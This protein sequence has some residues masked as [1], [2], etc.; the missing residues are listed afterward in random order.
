MEIREGIKV[1]TI[2][3]LLYAI[4]HPGGRDHN[5]D[6]FLAMSL[7]DAWLLA[8][9]DGLGG[10]RAGEIASHC[11]IRTLQVFFSQRCMEGDIQKCLR[12]AHR[13]A[14]EEINSRSIGEWA[15]MGTTLVTVYVTDRRAIIA[16]TGDSRA[17]II[18]E[19]VTFRTLD[20]S[21]VQGLINEG[22]LTEEE[23]R[24]HPMRNLLTAALGIDFRVDVDTIPLK[25]GDMVLLASDGFFECI[26]DDRMVQV[27][28]SGTFP[29]NGEVLL[30][31]ALVATT[32]NATLVLYRVP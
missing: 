4:S 21:V 2:G 26:S 8:V 19:G 23:A 28:R 30:Q 31:E 16:H 7:E 14:H 11:A 17:Y 1:Q 3:G 10:H 18:R 32:D 25:R 6:D 27:L 22:I 20:H 9:A 29:E 15:G 24:A 13:Q 12:A 5:E